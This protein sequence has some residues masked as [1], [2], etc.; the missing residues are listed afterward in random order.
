VQSGISLTVKSIRFVAQSLE[1]GIMQ[2]ISMQFTLAAVAVLLCSLASQAVAGT[3]VFVNG[4]ELNPEDVAAIAATYHRMPVA[5]RYW[6]DTISG[7][8]G[9]EGQPPAGFVM[10][11]YDFGPIAEDAS[12][13]D[14]GVVINGR[15]ITWVEVERLR[16]ILGV[17]RRGRWWLDGRTWSYG[18]EGNPT[19]IGTLSGAGGSGDHDIGCSRVGCS[20]SNGN[21]GYV[22]ADGAF[23]PIGN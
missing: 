18:V 21:S 15:E 8:W 9:V 19:P 23:V 12:N 3:N 11:G 13:G 2:R 7:A 14:T 20:N 1:E 17:V 10:P 5:G 16:Q 6:Y 22:N 4:N